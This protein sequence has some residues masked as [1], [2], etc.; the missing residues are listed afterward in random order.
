MGTGTEIHPIPQY[1]GDCIVSCIVS[2]IFNSLLCILLVLSGCAATNIG[3]KALIPANANYVAMGSSFAAGA[4]IGP[5]QQGSPERCSRTVNN[6]ASLVASQRKLNLIDVSCGGAT[7]DH[8]IGKWNEL[9][10]QIQAVSNDTRLVTITIGG[11]DLSYVG[12]LFASSCRFGVS[13][14]PGPCRKASLPSEGDYAKLEANLNAIATEVRRRAPKASI[15]FIQYV[16]LLSETA[17][18][19]EP[20]SPEDAMIGRQIADRLAQITAKVA[21]ASDALVLDTD[22]ASRSH[23]PCSQEPWSHGLSK[24]HDTTKGA[25]WHPNAAGHVAIAKL[26]LEVM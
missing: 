26:L 9:P 25:P 6:Y 15:V 16:T 13:V 18:P 1:E 11:N 17:C 3:Q 10:P 20:I 14:F 2:K 22:R 19:L 23:T 5:I 24:G 21:R 12:W 8:I 4:G 7:T